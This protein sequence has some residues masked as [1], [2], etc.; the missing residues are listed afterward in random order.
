MS[1]FRPLLLSLPLRPLWVEE[2]WSWVE[3]C[4]HHGPS[5]G[6]LIPLALPAGPQ[7]VPVSLRPSLGATLSR[8]RK[9]PSRLP[10]F[11]PLTP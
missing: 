5:E 6:N 9:R 10:S 4:T 7:L 2:A 1:Y 3:T 11:A 8:G